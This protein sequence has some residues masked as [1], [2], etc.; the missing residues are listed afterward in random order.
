M[1]ETA[2]GGKSTDT[3]LLCL[4]MLARILGQPAD[5]E[6]LQHRFGAA[7][8]SLDATGVL[9]AAKQIG[10]KARLTSTTWDRFAR[11]PLPA[12]AEA[13]DGSWFVLAK[14]GPDKV[15]IQE[16]L[17]QAP[18][19]LE[20]AAFEAL[21]AGR[22]ILVT[23]RAQ[24]AGAARR[25]DITWF[26]PSIIKYRRLFGDVL[27]ASFFLQ[28]FALITPLFF[29]VVIDKVLVH[30]GLSTL[31]VLVFGLIVVTVFETLLGGLRTYVFSHT[32]NRVDVELGARLFQHA[33]ALPMAYFQ[34]RR[35]GDTVARARELENIRSFLTGSAVTVVLDLFFAFVFLAVM[36]WYSPVLTWIVLA[37]IPLYVAVSVIVT[38]ILRRRLDEKFNRGAENQAFLVE[39]VT[40]VET[41]KAMAVEPRM[42][43]R[44]EE[45]LAGYVAAAFR[46]SNLSNWAGQAIQLISKLATAVTL[47]FGARLVIEGELSVGE[48]VAFNMLAGRVAAPVLRLAQ[49][50]QDFQQVRVS[51]ER[52]GDILNA[53]PEPSAGAGRTSLPSIQGSIAL[54]H[55]SFRYRPDGPRVLEE[56][57]LHIPA[58]QVLGIVGPSGSGKSTLTKLLQRLY[59]PETGRVLIDGIDLALVD[60]AWLRR[61]IGVVLQENVLFNRTVRDNIALSDPGLLNERVV[62]AARLAGA[63]E[64]ILELPYGYDTV[65]GERGATLSGGQRQRI[66]IARALIS[67]PRILIFDEATSALDYESERVIQDNMRAICKGRTVI[68]IAHRLAA[69]RTADR[70]VTVER[71]RLVED[72]THEELLRRGGRYAALYRHQIG[73]AEAV[74]A[75]A[76]S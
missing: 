27:A 38:P 54:E 39:A 23:T 10:F 42:Q 68:V 13:K 52:L 6:Q 43:Q 64:F 9:R 16:P 67:N 20:R 63:H 40:G 26:I 56:I 14:A 58:G 31:D 47:W 3:G 30:R 66:A 24:L 73:L 33:L 17:A 21:S 53:A 74:P 59:V 48:L 7:G 8:R 45:Q 1:A 70:I 60:P 22:L 12:L 37:T 41:L 5:P 25:F 4:A 49:L 11:V 28:L 19:V 62:Q 2:D 75:G 34:A 61:Q 32:T 15:L 44:W 69:V 29:Q 65:L 76:V 36:Y 55:V 71:G 35:V 51:L 50:W 57:S 18:R 46:A 72:G